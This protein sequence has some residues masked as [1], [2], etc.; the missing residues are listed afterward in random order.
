[1]V[2]DALYFNMA[3]K[4]TVV[5]LAM[6]RSSEAEVLIALSKGQATNKYLA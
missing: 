6:M 1:M 3:G 2:S 4:G 5:K